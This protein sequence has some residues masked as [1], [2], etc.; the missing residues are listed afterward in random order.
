M[1]GNS[2]AG[3]G[4]HILAFDSTKRFTVINIGITKDLNGITVL[5]AQSVVD[6]IFS[7]WVVEEFSSEGD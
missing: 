5:H 6:D 7:I 4:H 2:V 1:I 3:N